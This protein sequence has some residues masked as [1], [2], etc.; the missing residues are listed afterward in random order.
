MRTARWHPL[1]FWLECCSVYGYV[2]LVE[3]VLHLTDEHR[4]TRVKSNSVSFQMTKHIWNGTEGEVLWSNLR[5]RRNTSALS[6]STPRKVADIMDRESRVW[7]TD[8]LVPLCF[9][10]GDK[11]LLLPMG[12]ATGG[13]RLIWPW[14]VNGIYFVSSG[15]HWL[16]RQKIRNASVPCPP[17]FPQPPFPQC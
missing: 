8:L 3:V 12:S 16:Q 2:F 14:K 9:S 15:Y 13:D 4:S 7:W 11:I 1:V 17:P 10:R 6:A 5:L